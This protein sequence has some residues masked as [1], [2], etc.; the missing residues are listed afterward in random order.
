MYVLPN[1]NI[2]LLKECPLD[3]T[4]TNTL[5]FSD[6]D[7][8]ANYFL[9]LVKKYFFRCSYQRQTKS[10]R[11]EAR[12]DDIYDCNYLMYQNT[13]HGNKWFYAFITKIEYVNETTSEVFF[14]IDVMQTWMFDYT[15]K[16][17]F[18]EREHSE[19]DNIGDNIVK[20][21]LDIGDYVELGPLYSKATEM[22]MMIC[23]ATAVD[24]GGVPTTGRIYNNV[25]SGV[26]I[27]GY[28]MNS[29]GVTE[30]NKFLS[31]VNNATMSD[32]ILNVFMMPKQFYSTTGFPESITIE[33]EKTVMAGGYK[34][35]NKKLFTYPYSFLRVCNEQ[36]VASAYQYELFSDDT[37]CKFEYYGD[38]SPAP[39]V[40]LYPI[41][42]KGALKNYDEGIMMNNFPQCAW[43]TDSFRAYIAQN[44]SNIG[45]SLASSV[46]NAGLYMSGM[47][48]NAGMMASTGTPSHI[49]AGRQELGARETGV[50]TGLSI[51]N[52]LMG[53]AQARLLPPQAHG[54]SS[55]TLN[56]ALDRYN[57]ILSK[58][59]IRP[60]YAKIIDDYF[61]MFGYACHRVKV[62]NISARPHFN[63][64]K[65]VGC[66]I[67][68]SVPADAMSIIC[69]IYD[70]GI[71]FW[72]NGD[73]VGDY[74][75]DN[76]PI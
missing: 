69:S 39:S 30:L 32:S 46:A 10:M 1:T 43:V 41:S 72:K 4:Y 58:M 14:E 51:A 50:S 64:T 11:L 68:G 63:Y 52:T 49:I 56:M 48:I 60:E 3:N 5:W 37:E 71:T 19:T 73:E 35:R 40:L 16:E 17:S 31:S 65:T 18:V 75:I 33:K 23:V 15:L 76:S 25:Y 28:D 66:N 67:V 55:G 47:S 34:P 26:A 57:F 62:P 24:T 6:K 54:S 12:Y 36:G 45:M 38:L 20:E 8:Q 70:N 29:S 13:G 2:K 7:K 21:N 44:A 22:E 61:T 9:G 74:S 42:Y 27:S 53:I 59:S